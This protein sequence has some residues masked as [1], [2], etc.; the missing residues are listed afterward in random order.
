MIYVMFFIYHCVLIK[1]NIM[2]KFKYLFI[3]VVAI[4]VPV[5]CSNDDDDNDVPWLEV[6]D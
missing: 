5:S 2:K 1:K 4:M 6:G 3:M